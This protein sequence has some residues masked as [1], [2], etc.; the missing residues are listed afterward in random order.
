MPKIKG[1]CKPEKLILSQADMNEVFNK[2]Y[3][4]GKQHGITMA[5]MAKDIASART[6][7]AMEVGR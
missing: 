4:L 1:K 3:A 2:G 6:I 5:Q 7:N